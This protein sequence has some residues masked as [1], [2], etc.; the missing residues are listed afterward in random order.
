MLKIKGM[1]PYY[2]DIET[3]GLSGL[4]DEFVLAIIQEADD[5]RY[6]FKDLDSLFNFIKNRLDG[7]IIGFNTENYYGGFDI[8][9]LRSLSIRKGKEWAFSGVKHLDISLMVQKYLHTKEHIIKPWS[10]SKLKKPDVVKLAF[11]NEIKYTNKRETLKKL[12]DLDEEGKANWLEY[13]DEK[14]KDRNDLQTVYQS[15]FDPN[16]QEEYI[17]GG[18]MPELYQESKMDEIERHCG[19]DIRRMRVVTERFLPMLP[20]YYINKNII[21][22]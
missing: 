13:T 10:K 6:V 16:K 2:F 12:N 18:K 21:T 19:N 7:I 1:V 20:D 8:P 11:E 17:D 9:F 3:T 22:L 5:D 4:S 15:F 14:Y